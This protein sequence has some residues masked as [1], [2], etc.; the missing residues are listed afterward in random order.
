[1]N[2]A[3]LLPALIALL[4]LLL[5]GCSD[6]KEPAADVPL[7]SLTAPHAGGD[8][9]AP[10]PRQTTTE[11][12]DE[13]VEV[14]P[15]PF[16]PEVPAPSRSRPISALA[17]DDLPEI[18]A[19]AGKAKP[20]PPDPKPSDPPRRPAD[21]KPGLAVIPFELKGTINEADAGAILSDLL[22]S[23]IDS[24]AY[25]LF[26]RSQLKALLTEQKFQESDLVSDAAKA[27]KFGKLAGIRYLVLGSLSRLGSEYHLSA[28][29][30]DCETAE[31]GERGR[32]KFGSIN[33]AADA[34]P[35]L[36][37]VLGLRAGGEATR[38]G[39]GPGPD[40]PPR[41]PATPITGID[42]ID[43]DNPDATF[44]VTVRTAENKNEFVE[45]EYVSFIVEA[46]RDCFV[47][48]ITRDSEGTMSLLLPNAWQMRAFVQKGKPVTIPAPEAGFRFPIK[49]PH[50]KTILKAIATVR[51]LQ[52]SGISAAAINKEKFVELKQGTK[53][54]GLEGDAA[55]VQN[56]EGGHLHDLLKSDQWATATLVITTSD[57]YRLVSPAPQPPK[58]EQPVN[59][60]PGGRDPNDLIRERW[61]T[62]V[63]GQSVGTQQV[64]PAQP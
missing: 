60:P 11:P 56:N 8:S 33:D 13:S 31:I 42:L 6:A 44:K 23:E 27:A 2:T 10:P 29:V 41:K 28:R 53:A 40:G 25:R 38:P 50:G 47:T 15:L 43:A 24:K 30:V 59:R 63:R 57:G 7:P 61:E 9:A 37:N 18:D 34:L 1:M 52:L 22:L 54:I 17:I 48:L 62:E 3:R 26:E 35:E 49:P 12:I 64:A 14:T 16:V 55:K 19:D 46:D 51:P 21:G 58:R 32:V 36:V 39:P 45:K 20:A 5:P 4:C